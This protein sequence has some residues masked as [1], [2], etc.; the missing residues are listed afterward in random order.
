MRLQHISPGARWY[1]L[2]L[3]LRVAD[4]RRV[5]WGGPYAQLLLLVGGPPPPLD[6][7]LED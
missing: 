7:E 1:R 6:P 5:D 3:R 2:T 4:L